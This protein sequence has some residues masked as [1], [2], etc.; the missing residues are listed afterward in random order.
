MFVPGPCLFSQ[1]SD[2]Y[3]RLISPINTTSTSYDLENDYIGYV[4]AYNMTVYVKT[5]SGNTIIV[6]CDQ[7][8]RAATQA[9]TVKRRA[10]IP[11]DMMYLAN[12]GKVLNEKKKLKK[13]T[14]E[15]TLR[16]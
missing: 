14:L 11:R 4:C 16:L 7:K 8:Q 1:T 5:I 6:E 10:A 15:M 12:Q 13:T 3:E 2:R 9:E